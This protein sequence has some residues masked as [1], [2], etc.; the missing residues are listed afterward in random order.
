MFGRSVVGTGTG[1]SIALSSNGL[2]LW[3]TGGIT[4]DWGTVTAVS[5][6]DLTTPEGFVV[7]VGQKYLRYGQVMCMLS[8]SQA[9][10]LTASG[11]WTSGTIDIRVFNPQTQAAGTVTLNYN[12]SVANTQA[13]F[14]ASV[15][16]AGNTVVTGGGVI[17][18]NVQTVTMAGT[19]LNTTIPVFTLGANNIVGGGTLAFAI[20]AGSTSG[21]YGPYDP[22]VSDGRQTMTRGQC[23]IL[24]ESWVQNGVGGIVNV[25]FGINTDQIG[26]IHGGSIWKQRLIATNGSAS[27]ADGPTFADILTTFPMLQFVDV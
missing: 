9:Q 23:F 5:G 20:S 22:A 19:L 21:Y 3:K 15:L 24:N 12:S 14:D 10:T 4:I 26:A 13:A 16:G 8:A 25:S 18:S 2:P 1:T 17:A 7:P 27:L 11:T 6:S